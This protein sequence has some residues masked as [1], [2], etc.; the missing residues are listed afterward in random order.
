M[1]PQLLPHLPQVG[2][3]CYLWLLEVPTPK[4]LCDFSFL[5]PAFIG[6]CGPEWAFLLL[7]FRLEPRLFSNLLHI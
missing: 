7:G 2:L 1:V 4:F 3:G 5:G 6:H